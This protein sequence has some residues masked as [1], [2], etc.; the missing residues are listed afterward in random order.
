MAALLLKGAVPMFAAWAAA[1]Q[2]VPLVE[3][4]PIYG[5]A[6]P[7][8]RA[9]VVDPV[10]AGH[11]DMAAGHHSPDEDTS[12]HRVHTGDHCALVAL[13]ALAS[14][15]GGHGMWPATVQ[16]TEPV[17]SPATALVRDEA[18]SW[19]ARLKHGPPPAA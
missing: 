17:S 4:C 5:V 2:G 19:A 16:A 7:K 10:H 11:A 14:F 1:L 15:A 13:T 8:P 12:H 18:A 3:V 6:S 9:D